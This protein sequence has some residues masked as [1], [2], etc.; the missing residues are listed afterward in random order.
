M[1]CEMY[2][3]VYALGIEVD[4]CAYDVGCGFRS[5]TKLN[6]EASPGHRKSSSGKEKRKH[7]SAES[8]GSSVTGAS[9]H[10]VGEAG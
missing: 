1:L 7:S 5:K 2:V 8:P 6:V 9:S 3:C 10:K 4:L